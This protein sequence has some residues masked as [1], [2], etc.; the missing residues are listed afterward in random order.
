MLTGVNEVGFMTPAAQCQQD[1]RDL[2]EV[3]PSSC[4]QADLH[5]SRS[6]AGTRMVTQDPRAAL[7]I[8]SKS[9]EGRVPPVAFSSPTSSPSIRFG[10][11]H[12]RPGLIALAGRPLGAP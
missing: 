12:A 2:H 3:R 11:P 10:P 1:R 7:G 5:G 9:R 6:Y 8:L 4:D